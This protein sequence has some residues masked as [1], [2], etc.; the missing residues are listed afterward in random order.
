MILVTGANGLIGSFIVRE[1]LLHG[2]RVKILHRS[3]SDLTLIQDILPYIVLCEGDILDVTSLKN[4]LTEVDSII[5]SAGFISF[6]PADSERLL[7]VNAEGTANVINEAV[8][9]SVKKFIHISSVAALGKNKKSGINEVD[10]DVKWE[11]NGAGNYA[12]SK[13]LAELEVW[14]G[15]A[16]GLN[17]AIV[18]PSVVLGP[19]NWDFGSTLLFKYIWEKNRFYTQGKVNY[20]DVRD[21]AEAVVKLLEKDIKNERFILN[22]GVTDYRTLFNLIANNFEKNPPTIKLS[23][24]TIRILSSLEKLRAMLFNSKRRITK[25]TL[26]GALSK[27]I[28]INKKAKEKL[29][30]PFKELNESLEWTCEELAKKYK[31]QIKN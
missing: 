20:V 6:D 4:A 5:H 7:K 22:S 10:E 17:V 16:E 26:A 3:G 23:N 27:T 8:K 28:Y 11:E 29:G 13:Y 1:L 12:K 24:T 25:E 19:G 31:L 9:Q 21:V 30:L 18:N 2:Y 14:R 15:S